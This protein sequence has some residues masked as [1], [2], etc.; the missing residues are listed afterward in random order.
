LEATVRGS[1]GGFFVTSYCN[2]DYAALI[3]AQPIN[4][5]AEAQDAAA[6]A[7]NDGTRRITCGHISEIAIEALEALA[8]PFQ[9]TLVLVYHTDE[10]PHESPHPIS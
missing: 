5:A 9:N 4:T 7:S 8:A 3:G 6:I 10:L 2:S 1:S